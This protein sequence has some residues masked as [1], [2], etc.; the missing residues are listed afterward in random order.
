MLKLE[1]I[2]KNAAIRVLSPAGIV[3]TELVGD[4]CPTV[5]YKTADA[6]LERMLFAPTSQ[7]VARSEG[8]CPLKVSTRPAKESS[9]PPRPTVST[10]PT[11]RS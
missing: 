7:A 4:K 9:S 6:L 3:T 5:Y 10:W 1:Q 2:Q 8:A 11:F